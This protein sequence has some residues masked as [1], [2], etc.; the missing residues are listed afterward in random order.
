MGN[1]IELSGPVG[2]GYSSLYSGNY[3]SVDVTY[4]EPLYQAISY[5]AESK[6]REIHPNFRM[7]EFNYLTLGAKYGFIGGE[8]SVI[9]TRKSIEYR[10][11]AGY[12]VFVEVKYSTTA[13]FSYNTYGSAGIK[14][15]AG[16]YGVG[17]GGGIEAT[18]DEGKVGAKANLDHGIMGVRG[19]A[20]APIGL[21]RFAKTVNGW[22]SAVAHRINPANSLSISPAQCFV[23]STLVKVGL[24]K[25]KPISEVMTG[26][27][28]LA[29]DPL[30]QLGRGELAPRRVTRIFRNVTTEL[31][32]LF[33]MEA[34]ESREIVCTP[35]H[36]FLDKNGHF[37]PIANMITVGNADVVL[38]SGEVTTVKAE[39]I[40]YSEETADLFEKSRAVK[41]AAGETTLAAD[42]QSGWQTYNFE[43]EDFHTYVA[44][45]IRVQA[46]QEQA[47][48]QFR[49]VVPGGNVQRLQNLVYPATIALDATEIN[50]DGILRPLSP[51][52][53]VSVEIKTGNRRI[54]DYFWSPVAQVASEAMQ[55]R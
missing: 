29:F 6:N 54:I 44:G 8:F 31:V 7:D 37:P 48:P 16:I 34:G 52:M 28:V 39:R 25:Y 45:N 26:D 43:V 18:F 17:V 27:V 12:G 10:V 35:G 19:K 32:R 55:E 42:V 1:S 3:G 11:S 2:G 50:V 9:N 20:E 38:A 13:G 14:Y 23:A 49:S 51:G 15:T 41:V 46:M 21:E 24:D 47:A 40:I 53:A 5:G 30:D 36:H 33:W 22:F 4:S